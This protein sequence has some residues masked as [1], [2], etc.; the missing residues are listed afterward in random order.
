[1]RKHSQALW[2]PEARTDLIEI[3]KY[4][5]QVA[6]P[7]TAQNIAYEIIDAMLLL[8]TYP[9]G[10]RA[11]NEVRQGLRS[12]PA[13]LYVLFYKIIDDTVEIVRIL[14]A[15]RDIDSIISDAENT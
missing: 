10:G 12:L 5:E 7:Q 14:D 1:M 11:R 6:G 8:E 15:R 13:H 2:S 3:L 4:Y 9:L